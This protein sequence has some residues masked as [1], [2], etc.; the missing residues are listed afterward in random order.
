MGNTQDLVDK[1]KEEYEENV[2]Q[3]KKK[4]SKEDYNRELLGRYTAKILYK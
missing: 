2:R 3:A 4:N 1:F